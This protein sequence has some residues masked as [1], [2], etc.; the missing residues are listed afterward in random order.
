MKAES[1]FDNDKNKLLNGMGML[2]PVLAKVGALGL[3]TMMCLTTTDVAGRY[4]F[5]TPIVG[6]FEMTEFLVLIVI[7]SFIGFTQASKTHVSVEIIINIFPKRIQFLIILFNH[8]VCFCLMSLFVWTGFEKAFELIETGERS[9][10]L[11]IPS[12]PFAF[13]LAIG[14]VVLCVEYLRDIIRFLTI[15]KGGS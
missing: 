10:N 8:I 11:A 9:Q 15:K 4:F 14:C 12:Y 2:S 13:F 6:A 7:F 1:Y 5:N 3:F